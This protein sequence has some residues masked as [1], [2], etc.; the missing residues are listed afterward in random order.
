MKYKLSIILV[1]FGLFC[2]CAYSQSKYG[3]LYDKPYLIDY[4]LQFKSINLG[5][6]QIDSISFE[7]KNGDINKII[8]PEGSSGSRISRVKDSVIWQN[9]LFNNNTKAF[10]VDPIAKKIEFTENSIIY[11]TNSA[12]SAILYKYSYINDPTDKEVSYLVDEK[13]KRNRV[14]VK[15]NNTV[16]FWTSNKMYIDKKPY[17][18]KLEFINNKIVYSAFRSVTGNVSFKKT[19]ENGILIEEQDENNIYRYSTIS[20][21]GVLTVYD[22][23]GNKVR[24]NVLARTIDKDGNIIVERIEGNDKNGIIYYAAVSMP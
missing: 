16:L 19:F 21:D 2:S 8:L 9:V 4:Y 3:P 18:A 14:F 23:K 7:Y 10:Y 11:Y 1:A 6:G 22:L 20:G 17:S 13:N 24:T 5:V 12:S 15:K